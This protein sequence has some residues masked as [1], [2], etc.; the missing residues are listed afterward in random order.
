MRLVQFLDDEGARRVG[1]S[2]ADG[3][4]RQL[5]TFPSVYDLA[6]AAIREGTSLAT[7][8]NAN[9]SG[10]F[11]D[12]DA[13]AREGRLLPPLD[14]PDPARTLVSLTGLTH[15]GSAKS[16]DQMHAAAAEA[17]T[18]SIRMFKMGVAGGKPQAGETGVQPEWAYKGDGRAIVA[19]EQPIVQPAFAD[20][21]GEEAEIAGLYVID[22]GGGPWRVGFAL[23]NE[24]SD[25]LMEKKNYL[26]LAHSKLR[27]CSFGPELLTGALPDSVTGTIRIL[28]E[29]RAVWTGEFLSGE[30]NMCHSIANLEQHHFKHDL[31]RRPG[32]V[33]VHF[34]GA[35]SISCAAAFRTASGDVFEIDVPV[36]GRPLRNPLVIEKTRE[37]AAARAL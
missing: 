29:G 16:R 30:A 2:Q 34:F 11:A 35:S 7:L 3:R 20:D 23:G 26:Y 32:D 5:E 28:R 24:F 1:V 37:A 21:G 10:D 8:A 13:I 36:F 12:Y 6:L 17:E 31:F 14:H 9:L 27:Q 4:L 22:D 18:D 15:L 19:P 33:H 25:H